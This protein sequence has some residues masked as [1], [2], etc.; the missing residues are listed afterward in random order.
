MICIHLL[1]QHHQ[2]TMCTTTYDDPDDPQGVPLM[3]TTYHLRLHDDVSVLP[4]ATGPDENI[5]VIALIVLIPHG[6]S[7]ALRLRQIV[8]PFC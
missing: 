8:V 4:S 6:H 1:H 2:R 3:P 5:L 7:C